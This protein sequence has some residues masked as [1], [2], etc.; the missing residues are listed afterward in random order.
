VDSRWNFIYN[1]AA[2]SYLASGENSV[3]IWTHGFTIP[4]LEASIAGKYAA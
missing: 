2:S 4:P 1:A 3:I